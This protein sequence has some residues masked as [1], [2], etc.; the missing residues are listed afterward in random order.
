MAPLEEKINDV[1]EEKK[2]LADGLLG[3]EGGDTGAA[4]LTEMADA[5]LLRFVAL[6]FKSAC[7]INTD[8]EVR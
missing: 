5:E 4:L 8:A 6:D 3:D 7:R 2:G 1:I